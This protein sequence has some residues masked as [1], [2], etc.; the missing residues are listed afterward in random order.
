MNLTIV[1][2]SLLLN[3]SVYAETLKASEVSE[4][5]TNILNIMTP[6][7]SKSDTNVLNLMTPEEVT[8]EWLKNKTVT[9][10]RKLRFIFKTE[11]FF[12]DTAQFLLYKTFK[13][14]FSVVY[15]ICYA[16][17]LETN[18]RIA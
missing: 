2:L 18:C 9:D 5:D 10:L 14:P 8:N 1:L 6:E 13:N 4:N 7:E 16:R 15:V 12:E 3:G 11:F 17:L